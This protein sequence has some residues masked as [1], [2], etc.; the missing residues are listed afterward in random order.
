MI[1]IQ[2]YCEREEKKDFF[3]YELGNSKLPDMRR[4]AE[5]ERPAKAADSDQIWGKESIPVEAV[6]LS[7]MQKAASGVAGF[8]DSA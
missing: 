3:D 8:H 7:E 6:I 2:H 5:S 4:R 1:I